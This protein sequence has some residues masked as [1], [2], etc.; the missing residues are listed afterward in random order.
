L[1]QGPALSLNTLRRYK[2]AGVDTNNPGE[3]QREAARRRSRTLP[4]SMYS[5][6][7]LARVLGVSPNTIAKGVMRAERAGRLTHRK[8]RFD[9][10]DARVI[11]HHIPSLSNRAG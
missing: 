7:A 10:D 5:R 1:E 9:V 2:R 8:R 11:A 6:R 4:G 3:V